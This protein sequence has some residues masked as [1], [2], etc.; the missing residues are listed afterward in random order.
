MDFA[1][2]ALR[3]QHAAVRIDQRAGGDENQGRSVTNPA[4][5]CGRS[6]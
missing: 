3:D 4:F 5:N 1:F 6:R 2:G